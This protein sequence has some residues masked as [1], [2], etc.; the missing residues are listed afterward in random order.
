MVTDFGKIIVIGGLLA[1]L[2]TGCSKD[3]NNETKAVP[4]SQTHVKRQ[5][6]SL[7]VRILPESPTSSDDLYAVLSE[8]G[9]HLTFRWEKNGQFIE[10]QNTRRLSKSHFAKGDSI[11]VLVTAGKLKGQASVAIENSPP[12]IRSVRFTP[13]NICRGVDITAV[14]DGFDRDGDDVSYE[15]KW[16]I[17]GEETADGSLILKGDRINKGDTISA[18]ITPYDSNNT[19][20]IYRTQAITAPKAVPFFISVPPSSFRGKIYTYNAEAKDPDGG[21]INYSLASAPGGMT[22]DKKSGRISWPVEKDSAGL[23]TIEIVAQSSEGTQ[24]S[25]R[26]TLNITLQ[27]G[28]SEQ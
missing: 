25:Q 24:A 6:A 11:S 18:E 28:A 15:C 17:N 23:H 3:G 27:Q 21:A 14:P 10:G 26:Y 13:E 7:P 16:I 4:E 9:N 12:E 1:G 8:G 5:S 2:L 20:K 19:G 22:I